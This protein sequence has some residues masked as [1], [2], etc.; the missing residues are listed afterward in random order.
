[1]STPP[2]S[3]AVV[4]SES[5]TTSRDARGGMVC[6]ETSGSTRL[7]ALMEMVAALSRAEEPKDVLREFAQGLQKIYG[8]QAYVSLSTRGLEPGEYKITRLITED[9][10]GN[11]G[12][13]N[14]WG[15]W[16]RLPVHRGGVFG[17][18]IAKASPVVIHHLD[19][20]DDP[21]VGDALAK[22]GSMMAIPLFDNGEPI[23][24]SITLRDEPEG[25]TRP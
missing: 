20:R 2:E 4:P 15:E 10:P 25:Y 3:A 22:Y 21:A 11:I 13:A 12:K 8:S 17:G 5:S 6:L 14:P 18:I 24:W 7:P 16:S 9:V 19:L 23:N 1:M